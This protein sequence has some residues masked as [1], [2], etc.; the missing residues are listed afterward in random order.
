MT[1]SFF[2]D[3]PGYGGQAHNKQTYQGV[4]AMKGNICPQCGK[5]VMP[6]GRFI[7]EAEPYKVSN[8]G[9]CDTKL[10]RS[11]RVYLYL[12]IMLVLL[13]AISFP[14][15][16]AMIAAAIAF[17]IIWPVMILWLFCWSI[18]VNYFSWRSIGWVIADEKNK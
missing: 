4:I 6:Y 7:R 17:S 3:N 12:L 15:Y 8:C 14:L 1:F 5:P 16:Y 2:L 13:L 10:K 11:P 9:S 18:L